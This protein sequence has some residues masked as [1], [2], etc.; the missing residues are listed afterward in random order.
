MNQ[1]AKAADFRLLPGTRKSQDT[2]PHTTQGLPCLSGTTQEELSGMP[3][4][5]MPQAKRNEIQQA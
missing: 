2:T 3:V 1:R 5:V 4:R